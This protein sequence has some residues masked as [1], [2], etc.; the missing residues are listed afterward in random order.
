MLPIGQ[1]RVSAEWD[2]RLEIHLS[3]NLLLVRRQQVSSYFFPIIPKSRNSSILFLVYTIM[4]IS[5]ISLF[6]KFPRF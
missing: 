6:K 1:M 5:F 3:P 4:I 2:S